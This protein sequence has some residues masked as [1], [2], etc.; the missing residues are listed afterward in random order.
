M[1]KIRKYISN[2]L[3]LII[4]LLIGIPL[5]INEKRE[6]EIEKA[7]RKAI[8]K[9]YSDNHSQVMTRNEHSLRVGAE[10]KK[11]LVLFDDEDSEVIYSILPK[12]REDGIR[13]FDS[14][15]VEVCKHHCD[16]IISYEYT[17]RDKPRFA[18]V[19]RCGNL[20]VVHYSNHYIYDGDTT[21]FDNID[22][23]Y[24]LER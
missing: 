3:P 6:H 10:L 22:I 18:S 24:K 1:G 11:A 23:E 17:N 8:R 13:I 9:V 14:L 5:I 4:M 19:F 15:V 21:E 20:R 7:E 2:L 12:S 16:S